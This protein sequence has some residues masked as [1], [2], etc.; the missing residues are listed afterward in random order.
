MAK[1]LGSYFVAEHCIDSAEHVFQSPAPVLW[2]DDSTR[3]AILYNSNNN[4]AKIKLDG[5]GG[6]RR[7]TARRH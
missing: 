7:E 5:Q 1:P 2:P 4:D 6:A 3:A